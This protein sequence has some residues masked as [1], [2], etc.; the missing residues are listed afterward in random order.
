MAATQVA[1]VHDRRDQI[2]RD[3]P[4]C[5]AMIDEC[6]AAF[7][8]KVKPLHFIEDGKTMGKKPL[9]DGIDVD[10]LIRHDDLRAARLAKGAR[11]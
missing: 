7:G 11:K 1:K 10:K 9:F 2:R 6:R 5:T 4:L 8:P 3:F